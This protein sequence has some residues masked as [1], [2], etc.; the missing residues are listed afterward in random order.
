MRRRRQMRV[1]AVVLLGVAL[2]L[3][4]LI[5]KDNLPTEPWPL[6]AL[7]VLTL[8]LSNLAVELPFAVSLSFTFAP[9]FAGILQA[10]PAGGALLGL[11]SAVSYQEVREHKPPVLMLVNLCQ[12]FI[13][14]LL[15]GWVYASVSEGLGTVAGQGLSSP[16]LSLIAPGFAVATFFV[17]NLLFVGIALS[18]KTGIG[19]A[20]TLRALSPGSYWIS[21][22]VLA[23]LGYVM[24]QLIAIQSWLGLVLLVL[25]FW[26]ARRTFR[27][28]VEL[29]EAYASTVRSLVTA[30][31]AK[32]PYTKGHSERVAH[33]ACRL[34]EHIGMPKTEIDLIERAALLHDVG[35]IGVSRDVLASTGKLSPDEINAIRQHPA[36]GSDLVADVEFLSDIVDIVRHHHERCDGAG[37]P[38]GLA[39]ER[40]SI[41]ARI[42]AVAD[43]YDAMTSDRAY[44]P[45]MTDAQAREE[46]HRVADSQFDGEIVR[47][48]TDMLAEEPDLGVSA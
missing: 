32:D 11:A 28:Y 34:A 16:G 29:T 9:I 2:V 40:I 8:V 35:K 5:L 6:V 36:L 23:L 44:R 13:S 27:V 47:Q 31:E 17:L 48:F 46:L 25:P 37:Y 33:Y 45:R 4:E 12:L 18:L 24:A 38:D 43:A 14:G 20:D 15:A 39:G 19:W 41:A 21:L 1:Y 3:G 42:L 26:M 22:L 10:G 30:I 7:F